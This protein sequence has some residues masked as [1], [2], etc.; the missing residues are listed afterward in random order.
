MSLT[1]GEVRAMVRQRLAAKVAALRTALARSHSAGDRN[2]NI[3][4]EGA[5]P[6]RRESKARHSAGRAPAKRR[7]QA[8]R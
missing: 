8:R 3:V 1:D 4:T 5:L 6:E 7:R 2:S